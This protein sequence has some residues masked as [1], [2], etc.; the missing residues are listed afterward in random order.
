MQNG[1]GK[2]MKTDTGGEAMIPCL[3]GIRL[4][5]DHA[6]LLLERACALKMS[7]QALARQYVIQMLHEA[8]E[9][10]QRVNPVLALKDQS[11]EDFDARA[12]N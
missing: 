8:D 7:V 4:S 12:L 2:I 6:R 1:N 9:R 5:E 3:I 10:H 11:K